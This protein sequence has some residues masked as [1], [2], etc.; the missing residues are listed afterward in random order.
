MMINDKP[1]VVPMDV[2]G[3]WIF[4][5]SRFGEQCAALRVELKTEG[6]NLS[7]TLNKLHLQGTVADDTLMIRA[8]APDGEEW[9][10][11]EGKTN[12]DIIRG[13]A[14]QLKTE[15]AWWAR[16]QPAMD[17]APQTHTFEPVS[18][19]RVFAANIAPV[20]HI[21]PGDR[22]KTT[23]LDAGG[24]D[25][26]GIR[27]CIGGNP[28]TGPFFVEGALPGDTLAIK[29]HRIRLNRNSAISGR[30][31]LGGALQP[32]Y[33]REAKYDHKQICKWTLDIEA[34][35]GMLSHPTERL[36]NFRVKLQPILGCVAVA[37]PDKQCFRSNWLGSW[38]GNLDYNGLREGVIVYLP[39]FQEGAFLFV[40]DGHALQGDGELTG[41]AMETSMDVEFTVDLIQGKSTQ[42][43]RFENDEYLMT[44]GVAGSLREALQQATTELASWLELEYKLSAN[45]SNIIL[46]GSIRYDIAEVVDPQMHVVAK[47][48]KALLAS[49]Q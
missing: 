39:V 20:L 22:V 32:A 31:I 8:A 48:S 44:S 26:K 14:R 23:T 1:T 29:F 3:R 43:P 19:P 42:G 21:H 13:A 35:T 11:F 2:T 18:F 6:N 5:L 36:K 47:I 25:C 10:Q 49:L 17:R 33:Y 4:Y 24:W 9:G 7:G 30:R 12:G 34:A 46:G 27:Q 41:D 15:F 28:Q 45:E 37:P 40:G 16:R 38:G